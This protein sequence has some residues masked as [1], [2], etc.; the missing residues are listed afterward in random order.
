[1][2][3]KLTRHADYRCR[4]RGIPMEAIEAAMEYGLH[5]ATRGADVYTI[6]WRQIANCARLG[7]DLARWDGI[8]VVCSHDDDV[9]TAYRNENPRA[10]RGQAGHRRAA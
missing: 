4:S 10:L 8:E 5:R 1:M 2:H 7:I 6:G 3:V 9:V